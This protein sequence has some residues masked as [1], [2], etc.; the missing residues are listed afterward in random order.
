M[1]SQSTRRATLHVRLDGTL[2][3]SIASP[4]VG[5]PPDFGD[6]TINVQLEPA[7]AEKLARSLSAFAQAANPDG[8]CI[9]VGHR[10]TAPRVLS[11]QEL[12]SRADADR[13]RNLARS[14]RDARAP[15][16]AAVRTV[17][18][19]GQSVPAGRTVIAGS[20]MHGELV[21]ALETLKHCSDPLLTAMAAPG[22][23][24]L[25]KPTGTEALPQ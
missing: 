13:R 14:S 17:L 22:L 19:I 4:R 25:P 21:A 18:E 23:K 10:T 6:A 15:Y 9:V 16:E 7:E 5:Q 24:L 3:L 8:V 20:P 2:R 1:I 11:A 12:A